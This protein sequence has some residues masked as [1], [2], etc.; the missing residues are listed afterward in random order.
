MPEIDTVKAFFILLVG[1]AVAAVI[2]YVYDTTLAPSL[3]RAGL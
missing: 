1:S 3:Q 2:I